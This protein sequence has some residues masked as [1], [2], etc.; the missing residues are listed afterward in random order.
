MDSLTIYDA[1]T[2]IAFAV[3]VTVGLV[4]VKSLISRLCISL[5]VR[6]GL[7]SHF[8][9]GRKVLKL[10]R[11]QAIRYF[12]VLIMSILASQGTLYKSLYEKEFGALTMKVGGCRDEECK[13]SSFV[14]LSSSLAILVTFDVVL[15]VIGVFQ[16]DVSDR[17]G[18][19]VLHKVQ[20]RIRISSIVPCV[21]S[22]L[23]ADVLLRADIE[24]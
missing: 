23:F 1:A 22:S 11:P 21:I 2:F 9:T 20:V 3:S 7:I 19:L 18:T 15:T 14:L 8:S 5:L 12:A 24:I 4:S 10:L 13:W 6:T 16:K 17:A